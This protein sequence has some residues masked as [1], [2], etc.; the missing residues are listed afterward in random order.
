MPIPQSGPISFSS[1][2]N[3]FGGVNPTSLSEYYR[4][5]LATQT[6]DY[7]L[8]NETSPG[9]EPTN[10]TSNQTIPVNGTIK[11]S[12]FKGTR[13]FQRFI[14]TINP[15]LSGGVSGV[16]GLATFATVTIPS[17]TW[18]PL[19]Q[20]NRMRI[21]GFVVGVRGHIQDGGYGQDD[22]G[23]TVVNPR[24]I[25][26]TQNGTTLYNQTI[27]IGSGN[28]TYSYGTFPAA[29]LTLPDDGSTSYVATFYATT[30]APNGTFAG[31]AVLELN[32]SLPIHIGLD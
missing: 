12:N 1:L 19:W 15:F 31:S 5:P 20:P 17:M 6:T 26:S 9:N 27:S 32:T 3:E 14:Y 25:I 8:I 11:V 7:L 18:N 24:V 28:S 10:S 13:Q 21:F 29:I 4:S 23:I 22:D 2:R 16:S 30:F